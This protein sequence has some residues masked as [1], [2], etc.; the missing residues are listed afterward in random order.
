MHSC[1]QIEKY[2]DLLTRELRS[3]RFAVDDAS[4]ADADTTYR[5]AWNAAL[6]H[7]ET[8]IIPRCLA[9]QRVHAGLAE[10]RDANAKLRDANAFDMSQRDLIDQAL[11]VSGG[12]VAM[13]ARQ[14]GVKRQSLQRMLKRLKRLGLRD[15]EEGTR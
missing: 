10:L 1:T 6:E 12:N 9:E 11:T 7:V 15:L 2:V 13:A 4:R 8:V 14:L 3:D 5:Q